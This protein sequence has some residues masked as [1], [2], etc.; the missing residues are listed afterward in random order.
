MKI[1][2]IG[3]FSLMH[4]EEYIACSFEKLGHEVVR[5][6][7]AFQPRTAM[8][9]IE[10]EMPDIVIWGKL[11]YREHTKFFIKMLKDMGI[12]TV[13]W[14]FDLYFDYHREF[15]VSSAPYFKADLVVTTDDGHENRWKDLKINHKCVRQGI[16]DDGCFLMPFQEPIHAVVFV[17]SDNPVF[18]ER[19]RIMWKLDKDFDFKWYG[20]RDTNEV[21]GTELNELFSK[22]KVVVGDSF[23]SPYYWSNRIVETLGRGGFLIHQEVEGLKEEYP[24]LVTYK[25]GDYDDLKAK[26]QYYLEHEDERREIIRKNFELVKS[27][28]T[29]DK[30]CQEL[31]TC[32]NLSTN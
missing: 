31:L 12:K 7:Q 18:P 5:I 27:R 9:V 28:Y 22:S 23:Y 20:K 6:E 2:L 29:M 16:Y 24:D 15:M 4:D 26:I 13:C 25:R 1:A 17:G 3:K 8:Q 14:L 21:R 10:D 30:K 11:N 32:L 19:K